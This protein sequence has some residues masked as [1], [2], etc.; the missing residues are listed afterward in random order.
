MYISVYILSIYRAIKSF[1]CF[2]HHTHALFLL[3][4]LFCSIPFS[5]F[6]FPLATLFHIVFHLFFLLP[7]SLSLSL[8]L[9]N[10][11]GV[12]VNSIRGVN[13]SQCESPVLEMMMKKHPISLFFKFIDTHCAILPSFAD[14][15]FVISTWFWPFRRHRPLRRSTDRRD[16]VRRSSAHR[17]M[18]LC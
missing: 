5:W 16:C 10:I 1:P 14:F 2:S 7:L 6:L 9:Y 13:I 3:F 12:G 4:F 17:T 15:P 8:F 11:M 18:R